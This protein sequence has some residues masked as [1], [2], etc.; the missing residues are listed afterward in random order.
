M[1]RSPLT[2]RR[3]ATGYVLHDPALVRLA[4]IEAVPLPFTP[5]AS[6][7]EVLAYLRRLN[8]YRDVHL[9]ASLPPVP[10][11]RSEHPPSLF[12]L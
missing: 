7:A 10:S 5:E 2:V 6:G 1:A 11:E 8:P 3:S 12:H 4:G 9:E